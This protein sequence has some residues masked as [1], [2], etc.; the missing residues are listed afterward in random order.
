MTDYSYM[1]FGKSEGLYPFLVEVPSPLIDRISG[2]M[3]ESLLKEGQD[4]FISLMAEMELVQAPLDG[5]GYPLEYRVG[6]QL[7][8][9]KKVLEASSLLSGE[10]LIDVSFPGYDEVVGSGIGAFLHTAASGK[11]EYLVRVPY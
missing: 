10:V 1:E 9:V 4:D 2:A 7:E 5:D 11:D 8:A 3:T 6:L